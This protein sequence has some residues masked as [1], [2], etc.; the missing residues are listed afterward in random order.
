MK[1]SMQGKK[2]FHLLVMLSLCLFTIPSMADVRLP[3]I[4]ESNMVLQRDKPVNVWG[5]AS[6]GEA[7]TIKLK[8]QSVSVKADRKGKWMVGLPASKAGGPYEMVI[9]GKNEIILSNILIGDVWICGGQSNMQWRLDQTGFREDDS[10]WLQ[11]API[12]LFTVHTDMDYMPKED[13]AGSGWKT[14]SKE[15]IN[16]FSAVAYHFG[17]YINQELEV[18]IGL[19][20]DNLGATSIEAWMS[21]EALMVFPQFEKVIGNI[22]QQGKSFAELLS[23][24]EK[25][26]SRW[27]GQHYFK[28]R[29]VEEQ[30]YK[31]DADVSDWKPIKVAGNTWVDEPELQNHDGAVWFRTSFDLPEGHSQDTFHLSLLQIDD[32]DIVWIN[33]IKVGETYGRHNHRNYTVATALLK[34][35]NNGLVVRVFDIGG[36]GGFTTNAFWGNDILWGDWLYKKGLSIPASSKFPE[37]QLPNATPFSSPAVLFNANIA[38][39]TPMAIKGAIWYQGESNAERAY[40]YRELFPSLIK[41]WRTQF[42]QG[43][44]P[45]LFVQLANYMGESQVPKEDSWAELREAQTMALTLPNTGMATAIDIGEAK[46]IHPKNKLT[47]GKRLGLAAMKVAYGKDIVYTGPT[48]KSMD[49]EGETVVLKFD[50]IGSGLKTIDKHG[51]IRG[52]Q[53]AGSDEKFYWAEATIEGETV[54]IKSKAVKNPVAVRYAWSSNPGP[55]D[56][57][58]KEGLP[59]IPFRTD[60]WEGITKGVL[61]EDITRF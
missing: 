33:G 27:Y 21:N 1:F 3:K 11:K 17:K 40:E 46:D 61:F 20:S 25:K 16:E 31:P 10:V 38:P 53:V 8:D 58:N 28:G 43:D 35:K 29:G 41:D 15:N 44:F 9:T 49:I 32:Y 30:W 19:V 26:K 59:A 52:F 18:P 24:F 56:L 50:N 37:V 39:L 57:Y 60:A 51:Y 5:W 55:L 45:F 14:L 2:T 6:P 7:I 4:F 48:F 54:L 12:R 22:V 34:P 42:K 47:V 36:I 13:L 23:D